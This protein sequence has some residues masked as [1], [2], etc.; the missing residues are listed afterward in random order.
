M[1]AGVTLLAVGFFA[2]AFV[3]FL[4]ALNDVGRVIDAWA[5]FF[6][7]LFVALG[8][9]LA[10]WAFRSRLLVRA[11]KI[12]AFASPVV[13]LLWYSWNWATFLRF[14]DIPSETVLFSH[15]WRWSVNGNGDAVLLPKT[16]QGLCPCDGM[17]FRPPRSD[18]IAGPPPPELRFEGAA[19]RLKSSAWAR[20]VITKA[21]AALADPAAPPPDQVCQTRSL[22]DLAPDA[23]TPCDAIL[24]LS[25]SGKEEGS[26]TQSDDTLFRTIVAWD[27]LVFHVPAASPVRD[28]SPETL[29]DIFCGRV[30]TWRE[31]GFDD[32]HAILPF[33][34][35]WNEDA[36]TLALAWLAPGQKG[37]ETPRPRW[38]S[39]TDE[40]AADGH[41]AEFRAKPGAI[42]YSMHV[43][44]APLVR[45][46]MVRL[47]SVGGAAPTAADIAAGHYPPGRVL[48]LIT[49]KPQDDNLR[50]LAEF[51]R[52][53]MGRALLASA[54]FIPVS[55]DD[56]G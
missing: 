24:L 38:K 51:L 35:E 29:A 14:A 27:P 4:I 12:T 16:R 46:G 48:E 1:L 26:A 53:P 20:P 42:G 9:G 3:L 30:R 45:E 47:I 7:V 32:G 18:P 55:H 8:L 22:D 25:A 31:L 50:K 15:N 11:A 21:L 36:Q 6:L 28:L 40:D 54:G 33:E 43:M 23:E 5:L 52:S 17:T 44:A 19:P 2:L 49:T 10:A 13:F 34:R 37:F 39:W 41:L 56:N